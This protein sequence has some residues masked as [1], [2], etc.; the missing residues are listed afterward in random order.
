VQL[1]GSEGFDSFPY[2]KTWSILVLQMYCK[3]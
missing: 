3:V 2:V 1:K